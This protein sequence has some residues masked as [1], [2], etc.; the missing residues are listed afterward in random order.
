MKLKQVAGNLEISFAWQIK[1]IENQFELK[2][3]IEDEST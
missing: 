1:G 3:K 2:P